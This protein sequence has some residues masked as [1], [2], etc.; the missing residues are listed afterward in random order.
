M[1]ARSPGH[2][3]LLRKTAFAGFAASAILAMGPARGDD[4]PFPAPLS[5]LGSL[6]A[7]A[8]WLL[9]NYRNLAAPYRWSGFFVHPLIGYQTAQFSG[10]GGQLLKNANGFSLGAEGG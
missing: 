9:P 4:L 1:T 6:P 7:P 8:N 3:P 10:D 5:G 2:S